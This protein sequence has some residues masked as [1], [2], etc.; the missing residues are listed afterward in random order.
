VPNDG[1]NE[2]GDAQERAAAVL[3]DAHVL[4]RAGKL[5]EARALCVQALALGP[6]EPQALILLG[7]IAAQT[8]DAT[9]AVALFDEALRLEPDSIPAGLNLGNA[10]RLL[11]RPAEALSAYEACLAIAPEHAPAHHLRGKALA[12]LHQHEAALVSQERAIALDPGLIAAYLDR[13]ATLLELGRLED[14]LEA[15]EHLSALAPRHPGVWYLR[16][17]TLYAMGRLEAALEGYGQVLAL[18]PRDARAWHNC[19]NTLFLLGRYAEA[20]AGY[21]RAIAL[22]PR[23][24]ASWGERLH[25]RMLIA[26]WRNFAPELA[27]L[28]ALIER[29]EAAS[30]PFTLLALC[31]S[32]ALQRR[33]AQAW[34]R[35]RHPPDAALGPL[36]ARAPGGKLRIGYF[37]AEFHGH[38]TAAL[39]AELFEIHDRSRFEVIGFSLGPDTRDEMRRRLGQ[40]FDHFLDVRAKSDADIARLARSLGI[41]IAVDLGGFTRGGRPGI[42]ALRAAPVQVSYLGYLGTMSA[43]YM[44]YLIADETIVPEADRAHYRE[45]IVYLPSYQVNDSKRHIAERRFAREELG[46]PGAGIVF[47][48][49]NSTYKITPDTFGSWMRILTGVPGSVLFL[50]GGGEP[51]EGNLRR[52]ARARGVDPQRLVFGG[53]LPA[54][55]YLARYRAADLFLDTLPYNAGTT[56]SDALWSGLPVLTCRGE[57]FAGRIGASLLRAVG[58]PELITATPGEYERRAVELALDPQALANLRGRLTGNLRA[59]ALFDTAAF[60]RHLEAAYSVMAERHGAGLAPDTIH[61][62]DPAALTTSNGRSTR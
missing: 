55:E 46:L 13:A 19:A 31:G 58:L 17:N 11:G 25:A 61:A 5:E 36:P 35:E 18:S 43:G 22:D 37:S 6:R 2:G 32:P 53:R 45:K 10:L 47:C 33:A 8:G 49:F 3:R 62:C 54:P 44:D 26:D 38:A 56:A 23:Q 12:Q 50:L 1:Q 15:L 20:V 41:D 7:I 48:C 29:G 4:H 57:A 9:R 27:H 39:T 21:D 16:G 28:T 51:Q 60:A 42:F 34:V 30:N 40:A 52:E 24:N 59:T 14:A